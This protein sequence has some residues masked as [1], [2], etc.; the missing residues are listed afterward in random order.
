MAKKEFVCLMASL[1]A[2]MPLSLDSMLPAFPAIGR[3]FDIHTGSQIQLIIAL[4]FLGFGCGQLIFGTI[5][6]SLGRKTPIF[7][8]LAIF[9]CGTVLAGSASSFELF[10]LGRFSQGFGVAAPRVVSLAL[11]RDKFVGNAMAQVVSLVMTIFV[12]IPVVAPMLGQGILYFSGWRSIFIALFLSGVAIW[13][14]FGLRQNETLPKEKRK[15]L[16]FKQCFHGLRIV[17]SSPPTIVGML[18][19]GMLFG[20][21]LGY[22]GAVQN[23]FAVLFDQGDRFSLYFAILALTIGA[24]TLLNSRLVLALG[25]RQLVF[26]ALV[27]MT[28]YASIFAFYLVF[29]RSGTPPLGLFMVFMIFTFFSMGFLYGNLNAMAMEPLGEVAG[30]GSAFFGFVH[31]TL[32]VIFAVAVGQ[33]FHESVTSLVL[34]FLGVGLVSICA[35]A[36]ERQF[37][38]QNNNRVHAVRRDKSEEITDESPFAR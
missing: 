34:S 17:F 2:M 6:D 7:W 1:T 21:V 23:L 33:H 14:W 32:A 28:I 37:I 5:S 36:I 27:S 35:L 38:R 24:A 3:E 22:L 15:A 4:L 26:L 30:I 19:S 13:M 12:L 25:M 20:N 8:G 11:I 10:L 9:I 29:V 16:T 31:S 18:I